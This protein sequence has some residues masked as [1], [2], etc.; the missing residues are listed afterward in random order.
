MITRSSENFLVTKLKP[1]RVGFLFW[2]SIEK[3]KTFL[4]KYKD[5]F[6]INRLYYRKE[7]VLQI[8]VW[9]NLLPL[10]F[11]FTVLCCNSM[12]L[13]IF[14]FMNKLRPMVIASESINSFI[15]GTCS[16]LTPACLHSCIY[17]LPWVFLY[18]VDVKVCEDFGDSTYLGNLIRL[19]ASNDDYVLIINVW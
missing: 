9:L 3:R 6:I 15:Q 10:Y 11:T 12:N 7:K 4:I 17:C 13:D 2:F 5:S 1:L 14:Y 19:I 18:T 16:K 8:C